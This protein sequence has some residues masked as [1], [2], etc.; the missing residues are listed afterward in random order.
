MSLLLV[1]GCLWVLASA[2]VAMLPMRLQM[3]PGVA[4]LIAAPLLILLIAVDFIV[5][6]ASRTAQRFKLYDNEFALKNL[7]SILA[8]PL[9]V[10]YVAR[11]ADDHVLDSLAALPLLREIIP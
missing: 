2:I 1:L 4:L 7:V 10:L 6:I 5:I 11:I 9:M 3:V 8:L